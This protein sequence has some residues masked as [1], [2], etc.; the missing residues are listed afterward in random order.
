MARLILV[1]GG[2][3][4]G[5]SAYALKHGETLG[6]KRVFIATGMATDEEMRERIR[7]HRQDRSQAGWTTVEEPTNVAGAIRNAKES[8]ALLVD[9]LTTWLGNLMHEAERANRT[10]S[11]ENI[12]GCCQDMLNVCGELSGT[13]IFVTNEVGMGI[14]PDNPL[15]RR[16]RDLAGRCNQLIAAAADEVVFVTCGLPTHIKRESSHES[17]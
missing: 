17:A 14:V 9:C 16:F 4:S 2:A 15:A 6:E 10:L 12:A 1:T 3:R 8:D 13:V 11:E 5:K 7:R